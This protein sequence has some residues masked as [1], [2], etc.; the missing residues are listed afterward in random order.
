[1]RSLPFPVCLPVL[2]SC[3]FLASQA[4]PRPVTRVTIHAP[5]VARDMAFN[6]ILPAG[7]ENSGKRYPVLYLLHGVTKT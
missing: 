2:V 7:Y 1:M 6:L 3:C 4:E 5:S